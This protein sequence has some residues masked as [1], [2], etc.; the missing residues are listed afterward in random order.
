MTWCCETQLGGQI[1]A[2][3][4]PWQGDTVTLLSVPSSSSTLPAGDLSAPGG[5]ITA[6]ASRRRYLGAA[7]HGL[8]SK[9]CPS[10]QPALPGPNEFLRVGTGLLGTLGEARTKEESDEHSCQRGGRQDP[11][12][13]NQCRGHRADVLQ[14]A[15]PGR[16]PGTVPGPSSLLDTAPGVHTLGATGV[17]LRGPLQSTYSG[18]LWGCL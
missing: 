14:G 10:M 17:P 13:P 8:I 4:G 1:K 9:L 5:P 12:L 18:E 15:A 16:I 7:T 2:S 6:R 3:A 11:V